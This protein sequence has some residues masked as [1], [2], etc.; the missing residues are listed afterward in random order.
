[1][2]F[3]LDG[4]LYGSD[5][6]VSR[7]NAEAVET[8]HKAGFTIAFCSG[9]G[10]TMYVPSPGELGL[11]DYYMVGYNGAV[12]FHIDANGRII[13]R[14]FETKMTDAQV[15]KVLS[16]AAGLAVE[17][18][19]GEE[20]FAL[21]PEGVEEAE[22]LLR[23]HTTL[24]RSRY[25]RITDPAGLAPNKLT[26]CMENPQE[27]VADCNATPG[28]KDDGIGVVRGGPFWV[29]TVNLTHDK[30]VGVKIL[31]DHLGISLGDCIAFGDG[32]NDA[33][34]LAAC[35]LGI[36]MAQSSDEAKQA[37][38]RVSQWTN[39][40]NAVAREITALLQDEGHPKKSSE[41]H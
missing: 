15:N 16:R 41:P 21:V 33:T 39:D 35:G 26:V 6:Q 34:M 7:V 27:F 32:A 2:C 28:F 22:E 1:M 29:E 40:D 30:A 11:T 37:A 19:V 9:R 31:C 25:Q 24:V 10:P 20:Q 23:R 18:D 8:A 14:F 17:F 4:T 13:E 38:D 3:D 12:V 36:A 5:H